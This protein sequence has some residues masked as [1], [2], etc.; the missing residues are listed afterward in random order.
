MMRKM[1]GNQM[2]MLLVKE[3]VTNKKGASGD[4]KGLWKISIVVD[5]FNHKISK[6]KYTP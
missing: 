6:V 4:L 1:E 2:G 5:R 3:A